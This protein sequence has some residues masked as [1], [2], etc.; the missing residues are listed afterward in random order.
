MKFGNFAPFDMFADKQRYRN[1]LNTKVLELIR[2]FLI[3]FD[4][5][6]KL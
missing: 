4:Y 1:Y 5:K 2:S 3:T 6:L